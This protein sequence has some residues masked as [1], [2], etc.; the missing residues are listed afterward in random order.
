MAKSMNLKPQDPNLNDLLGGE[1]Q[2]ANKAEKETQE[3]NKAEKETQE[4]NKAE[5]ETQEANKAEKETKADSVTF[6]TRVGE[7]FDARTG[8]ER[9]CQKHVVSR[10]WWLANK[11]RL[12]RLG[13]NLIKVEGE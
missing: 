8:K 4:A 3:A 12:S 13:Y 11:G 9:P 6:Y 10:Q 1:T 7:P 5:K 2:E